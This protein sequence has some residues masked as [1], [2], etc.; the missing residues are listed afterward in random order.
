MDGLARLAL[1][2]AFFSL[3]I[4]RS[5]FTLCAVVAGVAWFAS[6]RFGVKWKRFKANPG[7]SLMLIFIAYVFFRAPF[8]E[9]G[10]KTAHAL[11]VYGKLI[12][13]PIIATTVV[14]RA[15]LMR[16]WAAFCTGMVVLLVHVYGVAW[17]HPPWTK[18]SLPDQIFYNPLPQAVALAIFSGWCA[19]RVFD[20]TLELGQRWLF[21]LGFLLAS[22]A[23]LHVSQQRLGFLVWALLAVSVVWIRS[24]KRVRIWAVPVALMFV[25]VILAVNPK[26]RERTA[27]G[28]NEALTYD[29]TAAYSSIGARLHMWNIAAENISNAP[30]WGY[31]AGSYPSVSERSFN[32]AVMCAVGCIHP[33]NQYLHIWLEHGLVGLALFLAALIASLAAQY[34]KVALQPFGTPIILVFLVSALLETLLWYRGFLYLFVPLL[35]LLLTRK[36]ESP[37]PNWHRQSLEEVNSRL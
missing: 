14:D 20:T 28:I 26:F 9:G 17:W 18:S 7:A 21:G 27:Q 33:H 31:G 16:C 24:P 4:S 13:I 22:A 10:E 34:K 15:S 12:L 37:T 8:G 29:G 25:S 3:A 5:L 36:P 6:G 32:D 11:G 35:G 23:V 1:Y 30:W 19:Y 2:G